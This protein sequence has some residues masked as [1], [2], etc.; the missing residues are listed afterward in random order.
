MNGTPWGW[1]FLISSTP[2]GA[3]CIHRASASHTSD[4]SL[5]GDIA[6]V[7]IP[8]PPGSDEYVEL[9]R[10][11][12][13]TGHRWRKHLLNLGTLVHPQTGE[14][15]ALDDQWF[16]RLK[17]N[18]AN[19]VCD[20]VQ[21][22]LADANNK[23]SEKPTDNAGEVMD[24]TRDGDK[25]Y[26]DIDVRDP[27]VHEGL[28]N[29]TILGASAFLHMDY[30]DTKTDQRVGPTLLHS[31]FTNRPY[32]TGLED[33]EEIAASHSDDGEVKV[34]EQ[35]APGANDVLPA[36]V[37]L[38]YN[39]TTG[40]WLDPNG[41]LYTLTTPVTG[42]TGTLWVGPAGIQP[43]VTPADN[44]G[45][46]VQLSKERQ[47]PPTKEELF[48]A[49]KKDHGIDVAALQASS[50]AGRQ[51]GLTMDAQELTTAISTALR[52]APTV[53]L[54]QE[55]EGA[56]SLT[57]PDVVNAVVELAN[58]NQ[59]L[60]AKVTELVRKDAEREVEEYIRDGKVLPKQRAAMVELALT[61]RDMLAALLPDEPV[62]KMSAQA[63]ITGPDGEQQHVADID[64]TIA[65]LSAR[66]KEFFE[67]SNGNR[68]H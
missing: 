62:I 58:T 41:T 45:Q 5:M 38:S 36:A 55:Q 6:Q 65:A 48:E 12:A 43:Q 26:V 49:L 25:V 61:N 40:Q 3:F 18:F 16:D 21:A 2:G 42:T 52:Q 63:G 57:G 64:G 34:F 30:K 20:I 54:S 11:R 56:T 66:H 27:K 39:C 23:H 35:P 1:S 32:V 17:T 22:P 44:T 24:I 51:V 7:L 14:K 13:Y 37:N 28:K 67:P 68:R 19:G 4:V 46:D 10:E 59:Q 8:A 15:L 29:R 47:M 31:C 60:G 50:E 9:S 33:Y 53:Q